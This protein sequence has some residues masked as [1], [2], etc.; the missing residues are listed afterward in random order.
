LGFKY[1][2]V[3]EQDDTILVPILFGC[4][5]QAII[6]HRIKIKGDLQH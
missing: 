5:Y 6:I 3:R 1:L 2:Y 4:P